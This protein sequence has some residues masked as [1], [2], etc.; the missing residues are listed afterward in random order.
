MTLILDLQEVSKVYPGPPPVQALTGCS[1]QI[2][3]GEYVAIM[4][5]SGSGKS[6]LLNIA[7]LLDRHTSGTYLFGGRDTALMSDRDR[8]RAR[9]TN[10][11]FVFQSFYLL[12]HR[13]ALENVELAFVYAGVAR[14]ERRSRAADAL[15]GVGL[16]H[17]FAALPRQLSGGERQRVALAR[18]LATRPKLLLCDEPTGNL[19]SNTAATIMALIDDLSASGQTVAIITHDSTIANHAQRTV[20][21]QDG[22]LRELAA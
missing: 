16:G 11:G 7:G 13:V 19:D 20:M 8:S 14:R 12:P 1:L 3:E 17:R 2:S 21:I 6:T 18:A 22:H 9:A 5:R 4:G 15:A 10:I